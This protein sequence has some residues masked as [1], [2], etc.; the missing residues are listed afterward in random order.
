MTTL[1]ANKNNTGS[2][3]VVQSPLSWKAGMSGT[4][5]FAYPGATTVTSPVFKT[6][7]NGTDTTSTNVSGAAS[8]SGNVVTTGTVSALVGG[9]RYIGELTAVV[10]GFTLVDAV[11]IIVTKAGD[12]Q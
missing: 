3:W 4:L 12:E 10:D 8:A 6:Y 2:R 11:M 9:E 1:I 7:K 5:V